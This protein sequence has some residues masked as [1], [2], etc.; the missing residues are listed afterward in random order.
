MTRQNSAVNNDIVA[1]KYSV[2]LNKLPLESE[3]DF[4]VF[5]RHTS[6]NFPPLSMCTPGLELNQINRIQTGFLGVSSHYTRCIN[7][8]EK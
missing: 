4:R 6:G 2:K 5:R 7:R 3:D 1:E 8:V